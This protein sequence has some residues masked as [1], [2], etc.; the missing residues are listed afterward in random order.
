MFHALHLPSDS[1]NSVDHLNKRVAA[2]CF[3]IIGA[4]SC[5]ASGNDKSERGDINRD[6]Y[7]QDASSTLPISSLLI[8]E[9]HTYTHRCHHHPLLSIKYAQ[10]AQASTN[11]LAILS[12]I[13]SACTH[14][15]IPFTPFPYLRPLAFYLLSPGLLQVPGSAANKRPATVSAARARLQGCGEPGRPGSERSTTRRAG[16]LRIRSRAPGGSLAHSLTVRL[17][18]PRLYPPSPIGSS[19]RLHPGVLGLPLHPLHLPPLQR[20][21]A[22]SRGE[23]RVVGS[24]S[25][26]VLALP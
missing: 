11:L 26:L 16:R 18:A 17:A 7:V 23:G 4:Q 24:V 21:N 5:A 9:C 14:I 6:S 20:T 13:S 15:L 12:A 22:P 10:P 8:Q 3:F 19:S 2:F 1:S 25:R